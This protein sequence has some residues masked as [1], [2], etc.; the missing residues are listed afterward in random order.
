MPYGFISRLITRYLH[1][2]GKFQEIW[3]TG[4]VIDHNDSKAFIELIAE[5]NTID[6]I[7]VGQDFLN[8]AKL[9]R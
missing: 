6:I 8:T 1:I 4:I 7:V 9:L 5:K 2:L 3:K